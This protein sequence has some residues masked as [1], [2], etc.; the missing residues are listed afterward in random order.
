MEFDKEYYDRMFAWIQTQDGK[1]FD[2]WEIDQPEKLI[3][4]LK[5]YMENRTPEDAVV[6]FNSLTETEKMYNA[7][8]T[9][10]KILEFFEGKLKDNPERLKAAQLAA[11]A[12]DKRKL[13]EKIQNIENTK[14]VRV[15][16]LFQ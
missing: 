4:H 15:S 16:G 6:E 3:F 12:E 9:Q 5:I 2:I 11:D 14:G 10:F 1:T 13:K 7:N 8:Y